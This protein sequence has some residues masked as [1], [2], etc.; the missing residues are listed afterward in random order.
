MRLVGSTLYYVR[1][2]GI[3]I[4]DKVQALRWLKKKAIFANMVKLSE[5]GDIIAYSRWV[6]GVLVAGGAGLGACRPTPM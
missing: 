4:E 6:R 5:K 3:W 1:I 2:G